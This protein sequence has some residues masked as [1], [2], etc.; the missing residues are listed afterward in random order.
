MLLLILVTFS[1]SVNL[2]H[3]GVFVEDLSNVMNI[4]LKL[5]FYITGI[6][7]N[8]QER[9]LT[10]FSNINMDPDKAEL[11]AKAA[12]FVN[13]VAM[14]I[15]DMRNTLLYKGWISWKGMLVW[16]VIGIVLSAIGVHTIYKNEN[17][18]VKVI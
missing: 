7:F 18:Y 8:L 3:Y 16:A 11:Y 12:V 15:R 4:V 2:M 10:A 13:P 1:F 9:L 6:F 17:S 14:T 5:A